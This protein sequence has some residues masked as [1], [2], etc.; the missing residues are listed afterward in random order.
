MRGRVCA[1]IPGLQ[2]ICAIIP[3]SEQPS[4]MGT[5]STSTT[6]CVSQGQR[7]RPAHSHRGWGEMQHPSMDSHLPQRL[8]LV[9]P[10]MAPLA[11]I[12]AILA[13][14][15]EFSLAFLWGRHHGQ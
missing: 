15:V 14:T 5:G 13:S 2:A 6:A 1:L 12:A 10:H 4:Y 7:T 3:V 8:L 9:A 11:Y